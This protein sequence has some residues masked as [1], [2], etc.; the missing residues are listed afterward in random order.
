MG[1]CAFIPR[2]SLNTR[3]QVALLACTAAVAA[4]PSGIALSGQP[5]NSSKL[6]DEQVIRELER[7]RSLVLPQQEAWARNLIRSAP[8]TPGAKLAQQLLDEYD[9]FHKIE[10]AENEQEL[11]WRSTVREY[12][13]AQRP[14]RPDYEPPVV[15]VVN[16][17]DQPVLYEV[18]GPSLGWAGPHRLRPG[19]SHQFKYPI[20]LRY[21][22]GEEVTTRSLP[23]GTN[24]VFGLAVAQKSSPTL[25]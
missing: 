13:R 1:F 22:I 15:C 2:H 20:V 19:Q 5:D 25:E 9:R 10:S 7:V 16:R 12:W 18:K 21:M 24:H 3:L 11:R 8:N 6:T 17:T 4:Y 23:L 14:P